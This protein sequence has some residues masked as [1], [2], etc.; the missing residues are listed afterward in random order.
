MKID[1]KIFL[2]Y[3]FHFI[4]YNIPNIRRFIIYAVEEKVIR[5]P[6]T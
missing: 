3:Q 5:E 4:N 6:K 1:H 2:K